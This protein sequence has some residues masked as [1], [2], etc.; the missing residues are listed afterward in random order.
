M[1]C[2]YGFGHVFCPLRVF[3]KYID[4]QI[5]I[6]ITGHAG[7]FA[8]VVWSPT[9]SSYRSLRKLWR[10]FEVLK[11]FVKKNEVSKNMPSLQ[12]GTPD[13]FYSQ[14]LQWLLLLF[15]G[16]WRRTSQ[17]V[18]RTSW[19]LSWVSSCYS[20][21]MHLVLLGIMGNLWETNRVLGA[22]WFRKPNGT[23]MDVGHT[24]PYHGGKQTTGFYG[25]IQSSND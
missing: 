11:T 14:W 6:Y 10:W 25:M 22:K 21:C 18:L 7:R 15:G 3:S 12:S 5:N 20:W 19:W 16:F 8:G 4:K 24:I 23:L 2:P 9:M 1:F 17:D 13:V